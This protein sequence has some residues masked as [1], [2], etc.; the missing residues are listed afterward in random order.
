[1]NNSVVI[2]GIG[3]LT[4]AGN[5]LKSFFSNI[6][7]GN[8]F[9]EED[10]YLSSFG[11]TCKVTARIK[12]FNLNT[13]WKNYRE[14][15]LSMQYALE[16]GY[17]AFLDSGLDIKSSTRKGVSFATTM[18]NLWGM[19][20]GDSKKVNSELHTPA[21]T[22]ARHLGFSGPLLCQSSGSSAGLDSIGTAF[23]S[24]K[25]NECDQMLVGAT[26]HALC[27][28]S[29]SAYDS[30]GCLSRAEGAPASHSRP[31]DKTRKGFVF[32]EGSAFLVLE[33]L[34]HA[35]QRKAH[36]YAELLSYGT[37]CN[38]EHFIELNSNSIHLGRAIEKAIEKGNVSKESIGYIHAHGSSTQQNDLLETNTIK[39]VFKELA[40]KIPISS[41][42]SMIGHTT[43]ASSILG[44]ITCI[45]ALN[46]QSVP[47]T[48]NL[49]TPD[50]ACDLN[51]VPNQYQKTKV[52]YA[53]N[54]ASSFA[55]IHSAA[56][57]GKL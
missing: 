31:F 4:P 39:R 9:V 15:P 44:M 28:L 7:A 35:L 56:I 49:T 12:N 51:Y 8:S 42:K 50:P 26:S 38:G 13:F 41:I 55:G 18:T 33:R 46:K 11:T 30:M 6:W 3:V 57:V 16:C 47:P 22:L 21:V 27:P 40:Y 20:S 48:I 34:E 52:S 36:I 29:F 5:N 37:V 1:M 19:F 24:L 14:S 25:L 45:G 23:T 32:S 54:L 17:Q 43:A 10:P 53:I 2:T